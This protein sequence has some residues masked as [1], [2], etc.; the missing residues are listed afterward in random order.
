MRSRAIFPDKDHLM[1]RTVESTHSGI[2]LVPDANVLQLGVVGISSCE[3]FAHVA[4][5]HADLVDRT[6]GRVPAEQGIYTGEEGRELAF[7]HFSGSHGKFTV[8][9]AA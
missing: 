2:A 3:H 1:L 4:P 5:I 7:T 8:L 6:I 9:D